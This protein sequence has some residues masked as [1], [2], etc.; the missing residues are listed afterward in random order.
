MLLG[1]GSP[2]R[3]QTLQRDYRFDGVDLVTLSA[4]ETGLDTSNRYG[5]EFEG[6]AAA[7]RN[8]G[9]AA[10]L[11]SLWSVRDDSTGLLMR[12]FYAAHEQNKLSRA[13]ALQAAQRQFI[14]SA[15]PGPATAP[16]R[17]ATVLAATAPAA[18]DGAAGVARLFSH[19]YHWAPFVLMG[20]WL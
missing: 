8:Q 18:P 17:G 15:R 2:L 5:Q 16:E 3:L 6:L 13:A 4:C 20:D 9:A 10:V 14:D 7:L 1:D 19:P 12:R 11:A